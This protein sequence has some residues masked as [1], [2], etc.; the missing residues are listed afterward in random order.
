MIATIR[1]NSENP[2]F[3]QLVQRLDQE[4]AMRDGTDHSFYARFN[5]IDLIQNAIV[6][7]EGDTPVGCGA[8]K[9]FST[10]AMEVKRM[11][12]L[13]Q[14]RGMGTASKIL[15]ALEEW[16]RELGYQKTVLETGRRQPE[17]IAL[18]K[19]RGYSI[20]PNYG[21]YIGVDNSVCFEKLV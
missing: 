19:N 11:Y 14:R 10:E 1:T 13:P 16:A 20:T 2:D 17:A 8:I 15:T 3:R 21:Q 12:V 18:Y 4:L 9:A 5:K 6:A 7:Y